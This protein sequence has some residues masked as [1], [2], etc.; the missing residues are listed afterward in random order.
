MNTRTAT[1]ATAARTM[2]RIARLTTAAADAVTLG[3]FDSADRLICQAETL[4]EGSPSHVAD[5][6]IG[7]AMARFDAAIGTARRNR[8]AFTPGM[9]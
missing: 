9:L 4:A 1:T 6:L 2:D 8:E 7:R 3:L 5:L